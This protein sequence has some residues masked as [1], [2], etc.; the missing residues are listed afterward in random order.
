MTTR[1][2]SFTKM[3]R[4]VLRMIR[5]PTLVLLGLSGAA[6]QNRSGGVAVTG[7]VIDQRRAPLTDAT[8]TLHQELNAT[9]EPV[10]TDAAGRFHFEGVGEGTRNIATPARRPYKTNT[11]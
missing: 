2:S 1:R 7:I 6:A 9:G 3:K 8:V 11:E 4:N 5:L 10:K